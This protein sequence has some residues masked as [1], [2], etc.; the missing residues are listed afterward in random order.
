[1]FNIN[2]YVVYGSEGVCLV[3]EIGHPAISGL[4]SSKQYYTL[5]PIY[6]SGKIYTPVDSPILVRLVI[7]KEVAKGIILKI[8]SIGYELDVPKNIKLANQYYKELVRSYDCEKL[9]SIIKYVL[10]KQREFS[11]IKKNIPAVDLNFMKIA[12]EML[13]G[14]FAFALEADPKDVREEI[15]RICEQSI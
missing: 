3:E 13:F 6:R 10:A 7:T 9:I 1:M 4:D 5:A 14:E 15:I 12:E 2:D 8:G 11:L